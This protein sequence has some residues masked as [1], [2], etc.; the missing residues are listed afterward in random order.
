ML[1]SNNRVK[2]LLSGMDNIDILQ[3]KTIDQAKKNIKD[4]EVFT[5]NVNQ[6]FENSFREYKKMIEPVQK[7]LKRQQEL[8]KIDASTKKMIDD[9]VKNQKEIMDYLKS[10]KEEF[11]DK[12]DISKMTLFGSYARGDNRVGSDIDIAIET[13]LTDYFRLYDLKEELEKAFQ[14]SVDIVRM[15]EKMNKSLNRRIMKDGIYV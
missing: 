13:K 8:V 7:E 12:Y 14:T 3:R 6:Q 1:E 5:K 2:L 15:R 9:A 4:Y 11:K 10:H